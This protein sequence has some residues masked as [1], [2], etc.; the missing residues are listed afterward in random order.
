MPHA[1]VAEYRLEFILVD[2]DH[3]IE[4]RLSSPRILAVEG[5]NLQYFTY[6]GRSRVLEIVESGTDTEFVNRKDSLGI[7][8]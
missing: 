7:D 2:C 6:D 8:M 5:S 1:A 3:L 4:E